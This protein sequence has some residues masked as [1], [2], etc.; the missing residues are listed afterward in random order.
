MERLGVHTHMPVDNSLGSLSSIPL[1]TFSIE[2]LLCPSPRGFK[3]EHGILRQESHSLEAQMRPTHKEI[4]QSG[5]WILSP[6][7]HK[8]LWT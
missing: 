8:V 3:K 5:E 1:E 7:K 6:G 2:A 4:L